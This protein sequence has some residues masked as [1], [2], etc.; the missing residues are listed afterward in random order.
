MSIVAPIAFNDFRE[1]AHN[2]RAQSTRYHLSPSLPHENSTFVKNSMDLTSTVS[3]TGGI[4]SVTT[5]GE[6]TMRPSTVFE[7]DSVLPLPNFFLQQRR[8]DGAPSTRYPSEFS[9]VVSTTGSLPS[10]HIR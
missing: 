8:C 9:G 2:P 10:S 3:A 7:Q 4:P 5:I 6:M 1:S